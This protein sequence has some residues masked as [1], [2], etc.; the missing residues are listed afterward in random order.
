MAHAQDCSL[1]WILRQAAPL[2][3]SGHESQLELPSSSYPL[4]LASL[5]LAFL[6]NI[7]G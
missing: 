4:N 5:P 6:R 7:Q 3:V 2:V 1:V